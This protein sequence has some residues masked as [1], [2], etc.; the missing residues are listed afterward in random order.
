MKFINKSIFLLAFLFISN[1]AFADE[2]AHSMH[3]NKSEVSSNE[4][5]FSESIKN[6][7]FVKKAQVVKLKDGETFMVGRDMTFISFQIK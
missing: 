5:K 4:E 2:N 7:N 1:I 3:R 6:L